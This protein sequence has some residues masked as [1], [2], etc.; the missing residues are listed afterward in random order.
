LEGIAHIIEAA[1]KGPY[2]LIALCILTASLLAHFFFRKESVVIK[3]VIWSITSSSL[4]LLVIVLLIKN[5]VSQ[6]SNPKTNEIVLPPNQNRAGT[7][8]PTINPGPQPAGLIPDDRRQAFLTR[9][10]R[11]HNEVHQKM[12]NSSG[13]VQVGGDNSAPITTN[14]NTDRDL[15]AVDEQKLAEAIK[16]HRC[17]IEVRSIG[18]GGEPGELSGH[19]GQVI[20]RVTNC[21]WGQGFNVDAP[22]FRGIEVRFAPQTRNIAE[23]DAIISALAAAKLQPVRVPDTSVQELKIVL[24]VGLKP[25]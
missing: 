20:N 2:A 14:V 12:S 17:H 10:R 21:D 16:W 22:Q 11:T 5:P 7:D 18:M 6:V 23:V 8:Q 1:S 13:G 19:I 4:L 15:S 25:R 24:I 3:V 9:K